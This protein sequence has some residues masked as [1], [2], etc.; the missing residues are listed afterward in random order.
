MRNDH[1]LSHHSFIPNNFLLV[2]VIAYITLELTLGEISY[3]VNVMTPGLNSLPL[4]KFTWMTPCR[5][6]QMIHLNCTS[7]HL[8]MWTNTI[9]FYGLTK[10][11]MAD[12]KKIGKKFCY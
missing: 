5:F 9:H 6:Y 11:Y 4:R 2:I 10:P 12:L 7:S 1:L 3:C 8:A